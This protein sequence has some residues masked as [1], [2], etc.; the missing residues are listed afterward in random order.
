MSKWR[1]LTLALS[2]SNLIAGATLV[3]FGLLP[4]FQ[5]RLLW[6]LLNLHSI[7]HLILVSDQWRPQIA[8][9]TVLAIIP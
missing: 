6:T 5:L 4:V 1:H 2:T 9:A 3:C 8:V 7:A